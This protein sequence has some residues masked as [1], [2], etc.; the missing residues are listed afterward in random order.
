MDPEERVAFEE[1]VVIAKGLFRVAAKV[2]VIPGKVPGRFSYE[3]EYCG[4]CGGNYETREVAQHFAD[5][6][7]GWDIPEHRPK[8]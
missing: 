3:C 8:L 4:A 7:G 1:A 6:H 2:W 5:I